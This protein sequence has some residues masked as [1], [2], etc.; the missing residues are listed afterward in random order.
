MN[1]TMKFSFKMLLL[2]VSICTLSCQNE[3]S[4]PQVQTA[5]QNIETLLSKYVNSNSNIDTEELQNLLIKVEKNKEFR[6]IFTDSSN[7]D[8]DQTTLINV[9]TQFYSREDESTYHHHCFELCILDKDSIFVDGAIGKESLIKRS[10]NSRWSF[11]MDNRREESATKTIIGNLGEV[12]IGHSCALIGGD[13]LNHRDNKIEE[14]KILLRS[15]RSIIEEIERV[16]E[17]AAKKY[18]KTSYHNLTFDQKSSIN[19]IEPLNIS[20][21]FDMKFC[22]Y[23]T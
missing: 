3:I 13:I 11:E 20:V 15:I 9:Q 14:L 17:L 10:Y 7:R 23:H 5:N 8:N 21:S 4:E 16:R 18:F 1:C 6:L 2:V 19:M 22:S 12:A